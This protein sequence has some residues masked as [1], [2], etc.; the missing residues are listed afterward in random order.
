MIEIKSALDNLSL[1]NETAGRVG[2]FKLV[3]AEN[4]AGLEI[5][6]I[7]DLNGKKTALGDDADYLQLFMTLSDRVL[8]CQNSA[9]QPLIIAS[10]AGG[11]RLYIKHFTQPEK[12]KFRYASVALGYAAKEL[13]E[14]A[15]NGRFGFFSETS[16]ETP[17][18]KEFERE[19]KKVTRTLQGEIKENWEQVVEKKESFLKTDLYIFHLLRLYSWGFQVITQSGELSTDY[20]FV[21][22]QPGK[23]RGASRR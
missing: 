11:N 12:E 18:S 16:L 6:D 20:N 7:L 2:G 19:A 8:T 3:W 9:F 14:S 17:S 10:D 21:R 4:S 22:P 15:F 23:P 1:S 5:F 13:P